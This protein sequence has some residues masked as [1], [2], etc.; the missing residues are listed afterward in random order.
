MQR[1]TICAQSCSSGL[2]SARAARFA[3]NA[4]MAP[5]ASF[6]PLGCSCPA[7][8]DWQRTVAALQPGVPRD[9]W[10]KEPL[11]PRLKPVP[12]QLNAPAHCITGSYAE[13]PHLV[14]YGASG[15]GSHGGAVLLQMRQARGCESAKTDGR[16]AGDT[17]GQQIAVRERANDPDCAMPQGSANRRGSFLPRDS[18]LPLDSAMRTR[19]CL[20]PLVQIEAACRH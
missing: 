9:R 6:R 2:T 7:S 12:L 11:P 10:L 19:G 4:A 18:V 8:Q 1:R 20:G 17:H 14:P 3:G 15:A 13:S 16:I 5:A